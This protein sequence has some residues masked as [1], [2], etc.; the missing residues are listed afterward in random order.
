MRKI[1]SASLLSLFICLSVQAQEK[2]HF[3]MSPVKGKPLNYEMLVKTDI[4]GDQDLMMDMT[5]DMTVIPTAISD[6]S[7]T[8][9]AKYTKIK[10]SVNAGIIMM[11]YDSSQESDDEMSKM[12]GTQLKPLLENTLT[13]IM[14][15]NGEFKSI[16]IPNVSEQ[17]F[18]QSTLRSFTLNYPNKKIA[19]GDSWQSEITESK[20]GA[21][22]TT[23]N[24]LV[25][26]T[27]EG[28]KITVTGNFLDA[29]NKEVGKMDGYYIV[30]AKTHMTKSYLMNTEMELQGQKIIA[31]VELKSIN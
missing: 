4:E 1:I 31:S 24:T 26:K 15:R 22:V 3:K 27:N 16:D 29:N 11:S 7:L 23:T 14:G 8:L 12:L 6:T 20:I 10:M 28:Y 5:M 21:N 13:M 18:D 30:D 2:V 9:E 17:S 19:I 25:Q